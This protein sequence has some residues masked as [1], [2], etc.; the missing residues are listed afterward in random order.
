MIA[1]L[2]FALH[3]FFML[4]IFTKKWQEENLTNAFLN[5]GLIIILFTVGWSIAGMI[6]KIFIEPEGFS[7]EFN[8]DTLSLIL[9]SIVEYFFY[10]FYYR[11]DFIS[12]D[13]EKQLQQVDLPE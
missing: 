7:L 11:D 5:L 10:K 8:R 6:L 1:G 4:F 3:I 13:K 12:T 2:I 9:L